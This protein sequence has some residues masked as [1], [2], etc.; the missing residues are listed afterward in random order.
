MAAGGMTN[1][2]IAQ[3]F[4]SVMVVLKDGDSQAGVLRS[5]TPEELLI[6]T[7]DKGVLTIKK[8]EIQSRRTALSP[9]PEGMGQ[10]LSKEDLRNLVE[11]LS[12]LK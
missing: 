7:P 9:M 11:F 10:V 3:G 8:A 1:K 12:S 2:Q 5:E 6:N 4:D